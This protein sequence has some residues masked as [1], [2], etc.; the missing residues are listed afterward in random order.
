[1]RHQIIQHDK[2]CLNKKKK[3]KKNNQAFVYRK[4]VQEQEEEAIRK[5]FNLIKCCDEL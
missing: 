5:V 2:F 4:K 3:Q 1:M